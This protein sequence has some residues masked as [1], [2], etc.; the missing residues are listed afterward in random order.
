VIFSAAIEFFGVEWVGNRPVLAQLAPLLGSLFVA[1]VA[2]YAARLAANTANKRQLEQ[3]KDAAGRQREQLEH[4]TERQR[5]ELA[6][7]RA[8]RKQ[9]HAR[10]AIDRAIELVTDVQG[11]VASIQGSVG[12]LEEHRET[13][14]AVLADANSTTDQKA[15]VAQDLVE[16]KIEL[17]KELLDTNAKVLEMYASLFRLALRL[18][19]SHAIPNRYS[20]LMDAWGEF[21]K[22]LDLVPERN[23]DSDE[24]AAS[25]AAFEKAE[26]CQ[27]ALMV[28]FEAWLR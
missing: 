11:E 8:M 9:E 4:D 14:A 25:K 12:W 22:T 3:L 19:A 15:H 10:D 18:E 28:E 21:I 16:K 7:D 2:A 1:G 13:Q 26:K 24:L 23:R 17:R 27:S 20:D 6:H 5:E